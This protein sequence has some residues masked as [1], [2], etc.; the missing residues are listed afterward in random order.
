MPLLDSFCGKVSA[1]S[2]EVR[3]VGVRAGGVLRGVLFLEHR[4]ITMSKSYRLGV[5]ALVVT[6]VCAMVGPPSAFGQR[7]RIGGNSNQNNSDKK[8]KDK[9]DD[10]DRK[11]DKDK[12]DQKDQGNQGNQGNQS[13]QGQG[14][15]PNDSKKSTQS[16]MQDLLKKQQGKFNQGQVGNQG[17]NFQGQGNQNKFGGNNNNNSKVGPS[18]QQFP[19]SQQNQKF[20]DFKFDDDDDHDHKK[21][22]FGS[23]HGDKWEGSNKVGNWA[24]TF[25]YKKT[26]LFGPKWYQDHPQA[27]K[28]DNN[29]ANVWVTATVP[30]M[31]SWLGWGTMPPQYQAYYSN[32]PVFD[33]SPYGDWYPLGVFSLMSSQE[34]M[35]TRI[36]QLAVDRRG[37]LAG[38]YFDMV[39]DTENAIVGEINRQT[40]RAEWSLRRNP[41]VTF[42]ASIYRLL[43]PYGYV[44]VRLPGG[45]QRW[46]FVRLEN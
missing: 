24:Q 5:M 19:Q 3:G 20:K 45:D 14:G 34:D 42:R 33:A 4:G 40:Q 32:A 29:K 9:D 15:N 35:G 46:Q 13:N 10:K 27:W 8:D 1:D 28:Y 31:Y 39:S 18:G 22:S 25:G 38:T 43:Q 11:K 6:V 37:R 30:G 12:N 41:D 23:W 2:G 36:V 26:S 16:Q 7:L 21:M 17:P 44:T